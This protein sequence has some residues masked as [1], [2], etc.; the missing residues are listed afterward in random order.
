MGKEKVH[1]SL[2]VIGHVDAGTLIFVARECRRNGENDDGRFGMGWIAAAAVMVWMWR[3]S[4][5]WTVRWISKP[6]QA[7]G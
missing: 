4:R 6:A 7:M 1:I 2:V 3:V 5:L